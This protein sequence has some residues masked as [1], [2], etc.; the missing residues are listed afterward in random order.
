[1]SQSISR[2]RFVA[3][4]LAAATLASTPALARRARAGDQA[5]DVPLSDD[6]IG[7]L[8]FMREEE[9]MA[10]DVYRAMYDKWR[11]PAFANIAV[12]EQRHMDAIKKLLDKYQIQDPAQS[13]VGVFAD[14]GLQ[15]LYDTLTAQGS[16]SLAEALVVGCTIEDLDI[17]DLY[18]AIDGAAHADLDVVFQHLL[19]GSMNHLRAFVSA[20][21]AE[22]ANY[23][24]QYIGQ[25]LFNAII[26]M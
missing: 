23:I 9:K 1:M 15:S 17:R 4:A 19:D 26:G 13:T 3:G 18:L 12:S 7:L 16:N 21:E 22:G 5:V 11:H 6:E 8:V 2:R 14:Q 10:R 25:E 24:P 20:L